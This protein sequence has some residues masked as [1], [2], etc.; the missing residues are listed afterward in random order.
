VSGRLRGPGLAAVALVAASMAAC[1]DRPEGVPTAVASTTTTEPVELRSESVERRA[2]QITVRVRNRTCTDLGT[3]SGTIVGPSTLVTNAHVVEGALELGIDTWDGRS[4]AVDVARTTTIADLAVVDL[5]EPL[6][7]AVT[8]REGRLEVGE[9]VQVVG[10]PGGGALAFSPGTAVD[11]PV[12]ADFGTTEAVLRVTATV[13]PGNS[14]GPVLDSE[15]ELVG[16]VFAVEIS[17]GHALAVPVDVL[18]Q[19]IASGG[20]DEP[21]ES[22]LGS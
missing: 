1:V 13:L 16:V 20:F 6:P 17:T 18:T 3:G 11:Y 9:P 14:G 8:I 4:L 15:G 12:D 10:Y 5:T 19:T 7:E 2:R 21:V 22:C